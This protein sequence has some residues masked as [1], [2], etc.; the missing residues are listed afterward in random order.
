MKTIR[1]FLFGSLLLYFSV[2]NA[3]VSHYPLDG[4]AND[5][6]SN[7]A[8]GTITNAVP[9]I[10]R[11][12]LPDKCYYFDGD[13][14]YIIFPNNFDYPEKTISFW[15]K[16]SFI[17]TTGD[18]VIIGNDNGSLTNSQ[19][20]VD[21]RGGNQL[22]VSVGNG[23]GSTTIAAN[24]WYHVVLAIGASQFKLFVDGS[25]ACM[26]SYAKY[27]SPSGQSGCKIGINRNLTGACYYGYIDEIKIFNTMLS[28]VEITNL[29]TQYLVIDHHP[30][31]KTEI[32]FPNPVTNTLQINAG[33]ESAEI[34]RIIDLNGKTVTE[35]PF[36]TEINLSDLENGCYFLLLINSQSGIISREKIVKM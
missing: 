14:D 11:Y 6:G 9:A 15:M 1:I 12:S 33:T 18:L 2:L 22:H 29:Y 3:Q 27:F 23:G 31:E 26:S 30:V 20:G 4:N 28:D 32:F 10:D 19:F 16:A 7:A 24:T 25:V 35:I 36:S 21:V 17:P 8:H 34:I 13:V 5:L